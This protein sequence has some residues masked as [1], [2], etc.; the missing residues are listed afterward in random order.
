MSRAEAS[1]SGNL[2]Q[3]V[4]YIVGRYVKVLFD[5]GAT[6]SFVLS[7]C[8]AELGLLVKELSFELLVSTPTSGKSFDLY[9]LL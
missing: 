6:H 3:G 1:Q 2:V 9:S 8:V 4:C 5:S 7:L